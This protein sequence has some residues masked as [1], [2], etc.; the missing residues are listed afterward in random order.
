MENFTGTEVYQIRKQLNKRQKDFAELLNVS[1]S[2]IQRIEKN[3]SDFIPSQMSK[4][5]IPFLMN[6]KSVCLFLGINTEAL[7]QCLKFGLICVKKDTGLIFVKEGLI[8]WVNF[9]TEEGK[10]NEALPVQILKHIEMNEEAGL[11]NCHCNELAF[12]T[13]HECKTCICGSMDCGEYIKESRLSN[14]EIF[15]CSSC[16]EDE[17]RSGSKISFS[18]PCRFNKLS[19]IYF[20]N[21]D[22]LKISA[23]NDF[24]SELGLEIDSMSEGRSKT[25]LILLNQLVNKKLKLLKDS[26]QSRYIVEKNMQPLF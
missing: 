22:Q 15:Y 1:L 25:K 26:N 13:C 7:W 11:L 6:E 9:V 18:I 14:E 2:T 24:K 8:N 23:V 17:L 12:R 4:N 3:P 10:L 16:I 19:Y 5:L 20:N 21:I